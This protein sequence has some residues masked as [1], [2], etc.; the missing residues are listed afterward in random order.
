MKTK[1]RCS[2]IYHQLGTCNFR[3]F[4]YG[5]FLVL[6]F[7]VCISISV[8]LS[9]Y[10]FFS[11]FV[12]RGRFHTRYLSIT[13]S[14]SLLPPFFPHT[15]H[16]P[17]FLSF[18]LSIYLFL[19]RSLFCF[20]HTLI[21]ANIFLHSFISIYIFFFIFFSFSDLFKSYH[22]HSNKILVLETKL[23]E[24]KIMMK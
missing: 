11:V 21:H 8:F 3:F 18:Y 15:S 13:I 10:C 20:S 17:F 9:I 24:L 19:S 5:Y 16:L 14:L 23:R 6:I 4:V 1:R 12:S 22:G 2:L 7:N